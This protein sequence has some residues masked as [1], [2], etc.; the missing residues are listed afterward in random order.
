VGKT[1]TADEFARLAPRAGGVAVR[2][3]GYNAGVA[4]DRGRLI[5]YVFSDSSV[6]R[7]NH[8]IK[9]GA[10]D[11]ANFS[12]N[13]VFLWAH[14]QSSPPIGKV[15]DIGEVGGKLRGTVEYAD[16]NLSPFADSIFRM[17]K[18]GYLNATSVAWVPREFSYTQDRSRPG[19][20][21]FSKVELLEV[22]QVPVPALPTALVTARSI[23]IDTAPF[24]RWAEGALRSPGAAIDPK[25]LD[26]IRSAAGGETFEVTEDD[27][28]WLKQKLTQLEVAYPRLAIRTTR[29]FDTRAEQFAYLRRK[30]KA[31]EASIELRPWG[32]RS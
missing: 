27:L 8:V 13:P 11:T 30:L 5:S 26:A 3:G 14:D 7:D 23:G 17:A 25:Q 22:S 24:A 1:L 19:G 6:G 28:Y 29:T 10:W 21:D 18:E 4:N 31:L 32:Y 16:A 2:S 20:I 9:G 15:V 12:R